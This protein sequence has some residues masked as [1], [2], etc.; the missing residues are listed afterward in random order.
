[1]SDLPTN[2][3]EEFK[4]QLRKDPILERWVIIAD[5]GKRPTDFPPEEEDKG[6]FCP[7]DEGNEDRTPP[8]VYAVRPGG[9]GVN[10][11]GWK[12]R[13]VP[14]MYPAV[15][16]EGDTT[17]HGIGLLDWTRG[18]GAHEVIIEHPDHKFS[19]ARADVEHML[20]IVETYIQRVKDLRGDKR[21]RHI[22]VFRNHRGAAGA[23]LKHPHSQLIALSITPETVKQ[24][25]K[26]AREYYLRKERCI[27]CDLIEQ[28]MRLP[29]RFIYANDDFVVLSPFAARFPYEVHIFPL[30]HCH[31]FTLMAEEQK[32]GFVDALQ[33]VLRR[34]DGEMNDVPYNMMLQTAPNP[35]P[36]P[37]RPDYWGTIQCDYHWHVE[38]L[39]RLTK[40]AGFEWGTGFYINTVLPEKAAEFLRT[41][42]E[43]EDAATAQ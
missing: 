33:F 32:R 17:H 7:F 15:I 18:V 9:G 8:E 39:P 23:S 41:G 28:E 30:Q 16:T 14:N 11:P 27:F 12:V 22:I 26:A 37:G 13:V 21:F 6:K 40:P 29:D 4:P 35:I 43:I 31:D 1:M 10:T 38:L 5:R 3:S 34:Y 36:R 2:A 20:L 19:F 42:A 24:K 25:L